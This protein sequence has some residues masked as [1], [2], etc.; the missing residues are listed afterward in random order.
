M[1]TY[2]TYIENY[3]FLYKIFSQKKILKMDR[4]LFFITIFKINI[5][6]VYNTFISKILRPYLNIILIL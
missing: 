4:L 2:L 1:S 3:S 6:H 5:L